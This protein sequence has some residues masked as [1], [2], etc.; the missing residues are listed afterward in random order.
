MGA[1]GIMG[2]AVPIMF[3]LGTRFIPLSSVETHVTNG[4]RTKHKSDYVG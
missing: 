4:Q 2:E 3:H 1:L